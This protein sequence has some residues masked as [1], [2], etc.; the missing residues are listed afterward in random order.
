MRVKTEAKRQ[1]I[2][3]AAAQVFR[4]MGIEATSMSQIAARVGGSKTTLYSYFPSKEDL[5]LEI[6]L[7]NG[8]KHE[9]AIFTEL[10]GA[11]SVRDGLVSMGMM[12]L[13]FITDPDTLAI[14]RLAVAEASRGDLGRQFY[15]RGPAS[16]LKKLALLIGELIA[17]GEFRAADPYRMALQLKALW[18]AELFDSIM[19]GTREN[20][21]EAALHT[22]VVEAVD[23]FYRIYAV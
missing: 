9:S 3:T 15:E 11:S 17:R 5:V 23:A 22:C 18:D 19:F 14:V 20:H 12:H 6:L 8:E 1:A 21:D 2:I 10:A 7:A 4:E 16:F 13:K